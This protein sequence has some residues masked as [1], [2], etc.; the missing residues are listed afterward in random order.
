MITSIYM[1]EGKMDKI[2][3]F[4][5]LHN[6]KRTC[7]IVSLGGLSGV[8]GMSA[9]ATSASLLVAGD[10]V[11]QARAR[12]FEASGRAKIWGTFIESM[13]KPILKPAKGVETDK[14][15]HREKVAQVEDWCKA[16]EK[17][18]IQH[19]NVSIYEY[20]CILHTI[21]SLAPAWKHGVGGVLGFIQEFPVSRITAEPDYFV[22]LRWTHI[23]LRAIEHDKDSLDIPTPGGESKEP[24][25]SGSN[26]GS[27][28]TDAVVAKKGSRIAVSNMFTPATV[29]VAGG[30]GRTHLDWAEKKEGVIQELFGDGKE[31]GDHNATVNKMLS[32]VCPRCGKRTTGGTATRL[33][34]RG[35]EG[36]DEFANCSC[37]H[38][39]KV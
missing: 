25:D 6:K 29:H 13:L 20:T 19:R 35:D 21:K 22:N 31:G 10:E 3:R 23:L 37:G 28:T 9:A 16:C 36:A 33:V 17:L 30:G 24:G 12:A 26:K 27:A 7:L 38:R 34:R 1:L 18:V 11:L 15:V 39:W 2:F 8:V 14:K 5:S 32:H 4:R